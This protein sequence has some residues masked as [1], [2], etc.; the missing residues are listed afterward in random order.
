MNLQWY[1]WTALGALGI[2]LAA[3][4]LHF[5]RL[6]NLG[7][8]ADYSRPAGKTSSAVRYAFTGA[9]NPARKESAFL[10]LPTYTAGILYHSGTFLS[11]ILFFFIISGI[12]PQGWLAKGITA[13]LAVSACCGVAILVKRITKKVL[14][15]LSNPDDYISNLLVTLF[16]ISTII[17]LFPSY[18]PTVIQ[19][20]SP[21]VL[22]LYYLAFGALML[23]IP[24]G[25]LRHTVYF[26]AARYH[27]GFF[28]GWRGVWP[29]R[30]VNN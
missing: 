25:K 18:S 2:C 20:Y 4:S 10:H 8:P 29:P 23:Y 1:Q 22:P 26:F 6:I 27:L 24:V 7:K 17:V 16:Q 3:C 28:F 19:S 5:I 13:F 11:L 14:R 12:M 15:S 21:P 30:K 9:M